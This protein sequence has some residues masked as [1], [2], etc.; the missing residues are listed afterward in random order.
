MGWMVDKRFLN[1]APCVLLLGL[2]MHNISF[3]VALN[4]LLSDWCIVVLFSSFLPHRFSF[5]VTISS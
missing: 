2:V 1:S 4:M 5:F 3:F